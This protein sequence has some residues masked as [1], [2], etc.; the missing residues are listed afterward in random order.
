MG[1]LAVKA[2]L[3]RSAEAKALGTFVI[4]FALPA[5][6]FKALAQRPAD[7]LLD[8]NLVAH[9]GAGS[10]LVF[11]F[12][13]AALLIRRHRPQKAAALA[14][15]TSLSNSAFMGFPIAE[16]VFG[17][18]AASLLAVFIFVENLIPVSYTHLTLPTNREV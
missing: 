4:Q 11:I 14:I 17:S 8:L 9:Y 12:V 13:F 6:L 1:F 2:Q 10:I 5:L 3:L 7:Q 16:E 15:G 18:D